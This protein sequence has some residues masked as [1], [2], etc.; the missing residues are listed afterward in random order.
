[1]P[2]P[3]LFAVLA[4]LALVA[5]VVLFL[6]WNQIVNWF[7][8]RQSLKQAD[9]AN[10]AFTLKESLENG[11]YSVIQGIFNQRTNEVLVAEKYDAGDVC[12]ELKYGR[13]ALSIVN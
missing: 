4:G 10:L 11:K 5:I 3:I 9:R 8:N 6:K 1:M 13:E 7:R 2:F 12:D